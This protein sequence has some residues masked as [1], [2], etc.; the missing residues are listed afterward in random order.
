VPV[1]PITQQDIDAIAEKFAALEPQL[2]E[3]QSALLL[4]V[5]RL[6]QE[7]LAAG[8]QGNVASPLVRRLA[9]SGQAPVVVDIEPPIQSISD[10]FSQAFTPGE[11]AAVGGAAAAPQPIATTVG[12]AVHF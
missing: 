8:G 11:S 7:G 4:A 3:P 12:I 10:V 5:L 1:L 6:A 9:Q 2:P